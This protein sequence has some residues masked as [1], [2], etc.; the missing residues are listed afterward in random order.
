MG[1]DD[2]YEP[3][4]A[5]EAA[6]QA[7]DET[8]AGQLLALLDSLAARI[9]RGQGGVP[10]APGDPGDLAPKPTSEKVQGERPAQVSA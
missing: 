3:A 5:L 8:A 6:A 4:L 1:F 7:R 10:G 2:L 9:R